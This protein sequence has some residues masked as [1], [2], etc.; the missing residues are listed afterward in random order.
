MPHPVFIDSASDLYQITTSDTI[1]KSK[2][3]VVCVAHCLF[4]PCP[5]S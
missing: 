5:G 3:L 4:L 2:K 1:S